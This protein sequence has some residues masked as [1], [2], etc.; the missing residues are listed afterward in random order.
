MGVG[1]GEAG[2]P[3]FGAH[4]STLKSRGWI[5]ARKKILMKGM[6][7]WDA[8]EALSLSGQYWLSNGLPANLYLMAVSEVHGCKFVVSCA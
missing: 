6:Y 1:D 7:W 5:G 4:Q 8:G 3:R 2:E